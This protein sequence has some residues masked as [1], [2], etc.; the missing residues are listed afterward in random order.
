MSSEAEKIMDNGECALMPRLRFPEFRDGLGW[1]KKP[2]GQSAELTNER[3]GT[4]KCTPY[5]VTSGIG[6]VSQEEKFGRIIAGKSIKNYIHLKKNDFAYN[7]SA[8]KA[9]PEGYIARFV[10][11]ANAAVPNSIFTCFRV[12]EKEIDP[13]YLD[14]LFASNLHGRWLRRLLTVG[15]RAHGSLNVNDD[16]LMALPVPLPAGE[17]SLDEQQKIADCLS[18]LDD[19]IAAEARKL[20]A[21]RDYKQGLMQ[22]IFPRPGESCPRL[23]FPEFQVA[24]DWGSAALG[25]HATISAERARDEECVLMSI[26]SG[27]GLVSQEEKFGRV[28][29]GKQKKNYFL[30]R[31]NDFAYNKSRTKEFPE[32][33]IARYSGT[34]LAAVPNSIFTCFRVDPKVIDPVYLGFL[35][36]YNLHGKWLRNVL[37]V[38]ARIHGTLNVSDIDL[39]AIPIPLPKGASTLVEQQRIADCLSS[40]DSLISSQLDLVAAVQSHKRGLMQQLFPL[41]EDA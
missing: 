34:Q 20:K 37:T 16:D 32:G 19:L 14:Y 27:V 8:T 3:V 4:K 1:E 38:G 6:L 12:D 25:A 35:F 24:G 28:I 30:I 11:D 5:T 26:T 31:Q 29:A 7:K 10:A 33:C 22:Q 18:V 13:A 9:F 40:L 15:A 21:M 2:L 36:Q 39:M 23:R 41:S 17:K